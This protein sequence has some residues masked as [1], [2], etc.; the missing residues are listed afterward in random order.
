MSRST[1]ELSSRSTSFSDDYEAPI[2]L[3]PIPAPWSP[4]CLINLS[5]SSDNGHNS[6]LIWPWQRSM[7]PRYFW[8]LL[9]FLCFCLFTAM[10]LLSLALAFLFSLA[11]HNINGKILKIILTLYLGCSNWFHLWTLKVCLSCEGGF[12]RLWNHYRQLQGCLLT[13]CKNRNGFWEPPSPQ[14]QPHF[15]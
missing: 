3:A 8:L 10:N 15:Q 9:S 11:L 13:P 14:K 2:E 4:H 5:S 1:H 6:V 12:W 7:L